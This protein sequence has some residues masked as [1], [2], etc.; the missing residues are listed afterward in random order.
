MPMDLLV[1]GL[2]PLEYERAHNT[3]SSNT[4]FMIVADYLVKKEGMSVVRM[5]DGE[6]MLYVHCRDNQ[7][8]VV[9]P[10]KSP[11]DETWLREFGCLDIPTDEL[12]RR[13][14]DAAR[15]ATYFAP[16]IMGLQRPEFAVAKLFEPRGRYVD[17]WFVREWSRMHQDRLLT[18]AG[19]VL[20]I[21]GKSEVRDSF[22]A[23]VGALGVAVETVH[24]QEWRDALPAIASITNSAAP[25]VLFSGGPANKFIAI[26][27]AAARKVAIDLGQAAAKEW[28]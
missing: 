20:F 11:L 5:G 25:L 19:R 17:N 9:R 14:R 13:I 18:A 21:H 4:F 28:L 7:G 3:I 24:M 6:R 26:H 15:D 8:T 2:D 16:Q 27:A 1:Q 10:P 23:R 12:L 22:A